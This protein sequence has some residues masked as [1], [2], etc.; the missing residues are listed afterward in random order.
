MGQCLL[1]ESITWIIDQNGNVSQD[2]IKFVSQTGP[3][4]PYPL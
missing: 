3:R 4:I 1:N 2:N